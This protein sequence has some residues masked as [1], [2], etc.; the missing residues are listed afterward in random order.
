MRRLTLLISIG[1]LLAACLAPG[2]VLAQDPATSAASSNLDRPIHACEQQVA[3]W[4]RE[5]YIEIAFVVAVIIFGVLVSALQGSSSLWAKR[6]ILLLGIATAILTGITSRVFTADDRTLRRAAFE[7]NLVV[8]QLWV[9][10]DNLKD[11]HLTGTD[12]VT[13]KG[14]YLKKILEFQALGEKLNGTA[15]DG[16]N[17]VSTA[18]RFE[19]LPRVY[20]QSAAV[21]PSWV[22]KP[23]SDTISLYFVGTS[24]DVSLSNAKQNSLSDSFNNAVQMLRSQ[25]HGASD[26]DIL[27]LVKASAIVQD[28]AIAYDRTARKYTCYTLLRVSKEIESIGLNGLRAA[29]NAESPPVRFQTKG[30]QPGDLTSNPSSGLFALGSDGDVSRLVADHQGPSRIERLFRLKATY[31][32]YALAASAESVFVATNSTLGCTV[33]KYSL[34][35]KTVVQRLVAVHERCVGIA[36]DGSGFYVTIPDRKEIRHWDSWSAP[37]PATWSLADT[38]SPGYL[39]F[40]NIGNRLIVADASGK[41]YGISVSDGAKQLMASNLG[42]V[43]SIATSKE[44]ILIASGKKVLFLSRSDNHGENPPANLQTFTGGHIV[45]VAVDGTNGL[46]FA[47]YDNKLVEGPFPVS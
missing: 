36:T 29:N 23:P 26:A 24:S 8:S 41:A 3:S 2:G 40:D 39:V 12:R 27:A 14:D 11:E 10:A 9:M 13:A 37:L 21:A 25:A 45:G 34:K 16:A 44:H 38:D 33:F 22:Q 7:G 18:N 1:F 28:S 31:S 4:Q 6:A 47:D 17:A 46:W 42:A 5:A 32:G 20:A 35:N 43:A 15:R 30:W 19:S